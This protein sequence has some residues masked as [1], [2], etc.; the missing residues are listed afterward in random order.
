MYQITDICYEK[1]FS[2]SYRSFYDKT[3]LW[4]KGLQSFVQSEESYVLF[5]PEE[6]NC[7]SHNINSKVNEYMNS[8][9]EIMKN[10]N[11]NEGSLSIIKSPRYTEGDFYVFVPVRTPPPPAADSCS[12]DNFWG[13]FWISF[14]FCTIVGPDL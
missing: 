5:V 12:R 11:V 3:W 4:I 6:T 7:F 8:T 13:T 10:C 14:I 9:E 2:E 1:S